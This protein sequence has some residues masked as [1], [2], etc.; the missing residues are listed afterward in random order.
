MCHRALR[1]GRD[2]R[3]PC[4]SD[5]LKCFTE[6]L[7]ATFIHAGIDVEHSG[8]FT[9][10]RGDRIA[11]RCTP[12][13]TGPFPLDSE[14]EAPVATVE[15]TLRLHQHKAETP[16]GLRP[17][18]HQRTGGMIG[19]LSHLVRAAAISA[20]LDGSERITRRRLD[21]IHVDH[22]SERAFRGEARRGKAAG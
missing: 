10:I 8:L 6:H 2:S 4:L 9:G 19:S 1:A 3:C 12:L 15:A 7:P 21:T 11:G 13:H 16:A 5:H 18:L 17:Y 22:A 20:I 14:W